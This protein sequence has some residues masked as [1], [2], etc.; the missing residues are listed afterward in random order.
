MRT[1]KTALAYAKIE[2]LRS[3]RD[4][5]TTVVLFGIPV[6][7]ILVFGSLVNND[8]N[9]S[10]RV[11]VVNNSQ[12]QF[13][14]EFEDAL[15][16]VDVF[17]LPDETLSLAEAKEKMK[18]DS[19]DGIIEL[20][21]DFG[22][23]DDKNIAT[24]SVKLYYDQAQSQTGD[25]VAGIMRGIVDKTNEQLAAAPTPITIE[26]TPINITTGSAFDNIYSMFTGM[27]IMMVGVFAV[28]SVFPTAKKLGALR[29]LH[30][31]PI[32]SGSIIIG[33]MLCYMVI[34]LIGV[35]MLTALAI[36]LFDLSMHGDWF[37]YAGFVILSLL[38]TLGIGLA[39]GGIAKNST[40]SDVMGQIVFLISLAVS[41]VWF[42]RA[43]MPEFLQGITSYMPLTPV[44]EG[45]RGIVTEGTGLLGLGPELAV[46]GAWTILVYAIGIKMFRWE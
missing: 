30:V 45:I 2:L 32:K 10:L 27:A 24:G 9:F 34:G 26:R 14:D 29:R 36:G 22:S 1:I 5:I 41:G 17:K 28:G 4:P 35:A 18:D 13:A 39:I 11:A 6:L 12:A 40:Q 37:T 20:P 8:G 25:I 16:K 38:M 44:I 46:L 43:L 42:P 15:A 3:M 23:V 19:L 33:T 31:T 21:K 7:L